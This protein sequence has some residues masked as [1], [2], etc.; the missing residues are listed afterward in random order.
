MGFSNRALVALVATVFLSV[1]ACSSEE[2]NGGGGDSLSGGD[3]ASGGDPGPGDNAAGDSAGGDT[4]GGDTGGGDAVAGDPGPGDPGGPP[5]FDV[6]TTQP[7]DEA[8]E[9]PADSTSTEISPS[10]VNL[11]A[12]V[13]KLVN[14]CPRRRESPVNLSGIRLIVLTEKLSPFSAAFTSIIDLSCSSSFSREKSRSSRSSLP[15]SIFEK[16]RIS[17]INRRRDSAED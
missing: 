11:T 7:A 9:V 2:E 5:V 15:A 14:T 12:L 17:S 3:H 1:P 16:S 6:S 8:T 4:S 10:D 13:V